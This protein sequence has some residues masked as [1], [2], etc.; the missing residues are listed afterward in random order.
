[1]DYVEVDFTVKPAQEYNEI[2]IAYLGAIGYSMFEESESGVKAYIPEPEFDR[3]ELD[4]M[5]LFQQEGT[6]EITY[7][8]S[9]IASKNWNAEW[10]K[11]FEPVIIGKVVYVRAEYHP[12]DP[13][14]RYELVIQ[15]RMAFGTGHHATTSLMMESMLEQSLAGKEILDMG[16]GTAILAMLADK[17]GAKHILAIDNDPNATENA[18][19]NCTVNDTGN[20][21]VVTGD[22]STPGSA[23]FDVI[24][25][26]INR[27]I[28]LEDL[29][30]YN[31][32]LKPGGLLLTSGYYLEDL[33]MIRTKA[34]SFGLELMNHRTRDNWCQAVFHKN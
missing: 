25:A 23:L 24:L 32:N 26:N 1:M 8:F 11:N 30:L 13:A 33:E 3:Q 34:A 27:N 15:P 6:F 21:H 10:E 2:V 17:M 29:T 22:A 16:C 20:I 28:I 14:F 12:A 18:V 31:A 4:E 9:T 19:L 5:P 7:N